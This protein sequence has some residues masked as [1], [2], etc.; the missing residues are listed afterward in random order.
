MS[1]EYDQS[2]CL[3]SLHLAYDVDS[4]LL[5]FFCGKGARLNPP[6]LVTLSMHEGENFP[7][8]PLGSEPGMSADWLRS[9]LIRHP[10]LKALGWRKDDEVT[11]QRPHY[12]I[13]ME[14][15]MVDFLVCVVDSLLLTYQD[16]LQNAPDLRILHLQQ[17]NR[18]ERIDRNQSSDLVT[19]Q[20]HRWA[21][22]FFDYLHKKA[23]CQK[24]HTLIIR[25]FVAEGVDDHTDEQHVHSPQHSFPKVFQTD[26]LGRSFAVAV[27]VTRS[28]VKSDVS[29]FTDL[30]EHDPECGWVGNLFGRPSTDI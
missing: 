26:V 11:L 10:R 29:S 21:N 28:M 3:E 8:N 19:F 23:W 4:P 15:F 25:C 13:E 22:A 24:L 1:E 30:L 12:Q 18:P 27:P 7:N 16:A 20:T 2:T 14:E 17:R 6:N 9:T 5:D